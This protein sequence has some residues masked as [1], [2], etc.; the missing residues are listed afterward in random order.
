MKIRINFVSN[1]SSA[2]FVIIKDKLTDEQK[3]QILN[4]NG[5]D[6][7]RIYEEKYFITGFTLMDN[8]DITSL[9]NQLRTLLD[10]T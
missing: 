7:W 10:D 2:S 9:F 8:G 3:E 6:A 1:S 4:Y 5:P